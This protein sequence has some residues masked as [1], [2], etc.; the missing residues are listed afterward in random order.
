M[1]HST[2][3]VFS[4]SL[5]F[6][7]PLFIYFTVNDPGRIAGPQQFS[8]AEHSAS[9][10]NREVAVAQQVML[11]ATPNGVTPLIPHI[12]EVRTNVLHMEDQLR[13]DGSKVVL[14]LA[15]DGLPT[16]ERG[17]SDRMV[18][19]RFVNSLRSLE[20]LPVWVVVRLCTDEVR[21]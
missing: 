8:I 21:R 6:T 7:K 14:V 15:T 16:D 2:F 18:Q 4:P 17:I 5:C 1:S 19:Q 13:K 20:G 12:E 9:E 10:I 3:F 11:N